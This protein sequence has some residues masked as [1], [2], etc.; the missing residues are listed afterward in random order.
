MTINPR[1]KR[2]GVWIW[3]VQDD[4]YLQ[5]EALTLVP[6]EVRIDMN[7][8]TERQYAS[9]VDWCK[10]LK[11]HFYVNYGDWEF[12]FEDKNDALMFKL[13]WSA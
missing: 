9:A 2:D 8:V 4:A 5:K 13:T 3:A 10:R 7:P 1:I 6:Y 12:R 11:H